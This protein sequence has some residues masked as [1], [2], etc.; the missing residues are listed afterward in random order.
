MSGL[1][2]CLAGCYSRKLA[3]LLRALPSLEWNEFFISMVY[4]LFWASALLWNS[5]IQLFESKNTNKDTHT[6]R[7]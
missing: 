2:I 1:I 7:V 3:G 5:T 6:H 4:W